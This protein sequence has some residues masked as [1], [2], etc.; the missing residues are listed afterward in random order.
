MRTTTTYPIPLNV[1]ILPKRVGNIQ[2]SPNVS[3]N[4]YH[5]NLHEKSCYIQHRRTDVPTSTT[6]L[7]PVLNRT[8]VICFY[9]SND[10][11]I[12]M[13]RFGAVLQLDMCSSLVTLFGHVEGNRTRF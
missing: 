5:H 13:T 7:L 8:Y 11:F 10:S 2:F 3:N 4:C 9:F 6:V 1:A 12:Q